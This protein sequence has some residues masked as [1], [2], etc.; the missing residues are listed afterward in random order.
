MR[1]RTHIKARCTFP[2]CRKKQTS[3]RNGF[4]K[5]HMCRCYLGICKVHGYT[6]WA[7]K[8]IAHAVKKESKK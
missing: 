7:N 6:E 4:C 1:G 5:F 3:D 8:R 2:G